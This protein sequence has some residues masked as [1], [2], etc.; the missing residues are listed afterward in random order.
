MAQISIATAIRD[1]YSAP[2]EAAVTAERQYRAIW[3][4]WIEQRL[5]L[6]TLPDGGLRQGVNLAEILE[7]APIVRVDGRVEMAISMRIA[8]ARERKGEAGGSLGLG[9]ISIGGTYSFMERGSQESTFQASTVMT[10]SNN[11]KT[12]S[13][14]LGENRINATTPEELTAAVEFLREEKQEDGD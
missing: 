8:T 3:A 7:T 1:L 2:L 11:E 5:A 12:L 9:P 10:V 6:A 4:D 13:E 14:L